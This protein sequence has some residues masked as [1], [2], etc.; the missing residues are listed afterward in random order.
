MAVR[1]TAQVGHPALQ[2]ANEIISNFS[3]T[4]IL[5][6]IQDLEDTMLAADLIGLAA[7]QI[8]ENHQVFITQ[9]RKTKSRPEI[10]DE[11]RVYINPTITQFSDETVTIFEG[12]GSVVHGQLFGPVSRPKTITIEAFDRVGKKFS[13]T[14]DGI[15]ARVIQHEYD[16]L[17][18]VEFLEKVSDYREMMA[19]EHYKENVA[20]S[21]PHIDASQ[22]SALEFKYL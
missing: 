9:P 17:Q 12:C 2:S 4:K 21:Q 1:R 13:L 5:S 14:C 16:H 7:P 22:I 15:L 10:A 8:G 3:D 11:L 19:L 6:L 18:G 20:T